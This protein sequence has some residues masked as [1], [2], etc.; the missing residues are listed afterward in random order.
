M[1]ILKYSLIIS[2]LALTYHTNTFAKTRIIG[3]KP[4][5]FPWMVAIVEANVPA[6][7]GVVCGGTLIDPEWVLTAA[8]C[9][10]GESEKSI[11]VFVGN[12][13]LNSKQGTRISIAEMIVHPEYDKDPNAPIADIALLRLKTP[14]HEQEI[15]H[16]TSSY[17]DLDKPGQMGVIA[18]WGATNPEL[19]YISFSDVLLKTSVPIVSN[20]VCN[21]S[22]EGDVDGRM[23]CAGYEKGE[24]DA[25]VGDS[26]GPIVIWNDSDWEQVGIVSFGEGCAQANYYGVYTRVAS[27][28]DFIAEHVCQNTPMPSQPTI[29]ANVTGNNVHINWDAVENAD[30]YQLYYT[31]YVPTIE[32]I[33]FDRIHSVYVG[34]QTQ[35]NAI[36]E[37]GDA[38]Y[39]SV[40]AYQGNCWSVYSNIEM[41]RVE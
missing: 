37:K 8:H 20:D 18:G 40:R 41:I 30:G 36:V 26:G 31:S 32:D 39:V 35:F 22:Y 34:K 10:L 29:Q 28:E 19:P 1:N 12:R 25:C 27:F 2:M 11:D 14:Y 9:T 24:I 13:D 6:S 38:Y 16:I 3:G 33:Q 5:D 15:I 17:T 21:Q 4:A 23:L 7:D